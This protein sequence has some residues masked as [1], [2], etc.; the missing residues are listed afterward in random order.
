MN[1][2][3]RRMAE[4]CRLE[5]GRR[6]AQRRND[7]A[8]E[9]GGDRGDSPGPGKPLVLG[10]ALVGGGGKEGSKVIPK[11]PFQV[12]GRMTVPG[13]QAGLSERDEEVQGHLDGDLWWVLC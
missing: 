6:L 9:D 11:F 3:R 7:R 12:A 2:G 4:R 5:M 1:K 8:G 13:E 10:R